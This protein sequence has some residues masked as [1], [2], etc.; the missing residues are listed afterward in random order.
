MG[1]L[2]RKDSGIMTGASVPFTISTADLAV[3]NILCVY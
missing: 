2:Y 1:L 3:D